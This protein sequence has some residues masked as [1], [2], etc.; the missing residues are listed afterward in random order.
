MDRSATVDQTVR[1]STVTVL[2]V[3]LFALACSENP[4]SIARIPFLHPF[5]GM[6]GSSACDDGEEWIEETGHVA[7]DSTGLI[8]PTTCWEYAESVSVSVE[9][10]YAFL[11]GHPEPGWLWHTMRL[12]YLDYHCF[13]PDSGATF[14]VLDSLHLEDDSSK[15][16]F[17]KSIV[18][19]ASPGCAFVA[20][21]A[22]SAV[23][24]G[25][26]WFAYVRILTA[27]DN[28]PPSSLAGSFDGVAVNLTWS[29]NL[30]VS[31]QLKR[32]PNTYFV[33]DS[34]FASYADS[35]WDYDTTYEYWARHYA[36]PD[37]TETKARITDWSDSVQVVIPDSL[38]AYVSG[39]DTIPP[40]E[41]CAWT[42]VGEKGTSPY[43]YSW[44]GDVQG[45]SPIITESFAWRRDP[46][47]LALTVMDS[48]GWEAFDTLLVVVDKGLRGQECEQR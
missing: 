46:Y 45:T 40:D 41:V 13:L 16:W 9:F 48:L 35:M 12:Y 10:S 21:S 22:D 26:D 31:T 42:G 44:S 29:K 8:L 24:G 32:S 17:E 30:A 2:A 7:A 37:W 3:G 28:D 25:S 38:I 27:L 11:P 6:V 14:E 19:P 20:V 4:T 39:L 23:R 47:T 18:L 15:H 5:A 34:A 43:S 36:S 1:G 33:V